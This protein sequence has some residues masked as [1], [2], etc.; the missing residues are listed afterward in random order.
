M[1][2]QI[3]ARSGVENISIMDPDVFENVNINN[4]FNAFMS[5]M[6]ENKA[7]VVG[8]MLKDIN[9]SA[10]IDVHPEGLTDANVKTM[11]NWADVILDCV[12]Y[13]ELYYSYIL[14]REARK[15]GKFVLA[16]QA[17][18]YGGSV[19]VFDPK[20]M[21]FNE[22]LGLQDGLQAEDFKKIVASPE[23]Y[24]AIIPDYIDKK[25]V[26]KVVNRQIPIPNIALAQTLTASIMVS[27][28]I[29][30]LLGLRKPTVVPKIIAIDLL[31]NRFII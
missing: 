28:V 1:S 9:P 4:Q 31:E 19:L 25:I 13:N 5:T 12:D 24:A 29:F 23:K 18:G 27:E 20:G 30:I 11:V 15:H 22:H 6:R 8:S 2:A 17:I 3:V 10:K 26:E 21:S 7:Q 14:N 16:P